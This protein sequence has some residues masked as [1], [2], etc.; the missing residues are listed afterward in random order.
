MFGTKRT[1]S[2][3]RPK[4]RLLSLARALTPDRP[5]PARVAAMAHIVADARGKAR[6][7]LEAKRKGRFAEG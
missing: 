1:L 2:F 3:W 6:L 5:E 7:A 4:K